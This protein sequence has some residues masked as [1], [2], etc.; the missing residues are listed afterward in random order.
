MGV[1]EKAH[2]DLRVFEQ[3]L[4]DLF[5]LEMVSN[6]GV[7]AGGGAVAGQK[8][9]RLFPQQGQALEK[10][11]E[12]RAD[13]LPAPHQGLVGDDVEVLGPLRIEQGQVMVSRQTPDL[14]LWSNS[15]HSLGLAL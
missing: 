8:R 10:F 6:I 14:R 11:Q 4:E 2:P 13:L 15:R 7:G 3:M 9:A 1:A 12:F 5:A